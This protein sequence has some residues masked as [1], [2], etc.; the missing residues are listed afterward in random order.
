MTTRALDLLT[1]DYRSLQLTGKDSV[2]LCGPGV[3][4]GQDDAARLQHRQEL[5]RARGWQCGEE[6]ENALVNGELE[7][8]RVVHRPGTRLHKHTAKLSFVSLQ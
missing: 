4:V 1:F 3:D 6:L 8:C 2:E 5:G 7:H